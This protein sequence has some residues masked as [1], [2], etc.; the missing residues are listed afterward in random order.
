MAALTVG[1]G[2]VVSA[3]AGVGRLQVGAVGGGD[4]FGLDQTEG[5]AWHF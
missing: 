3:V 5:N 2:V 4:F 1:E